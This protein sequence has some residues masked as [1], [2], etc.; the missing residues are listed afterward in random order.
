MS[1]IYAIAVAGFMILIGFAKFKLYPAL[2]S[3]RSE[4]GNPDYD[5]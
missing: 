2:I 5:H 4:T 3:K 1:A